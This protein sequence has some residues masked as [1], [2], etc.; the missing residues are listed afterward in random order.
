MA[1]GLYFL[2]PNSNWLKCV[3]KLN[4]TLTVKFLLKFSYLEFGLHSYIHHLHINPSRGFLIDC[5]QLNPISLWNLA[6]LWARS[7]LSYWSPFTFLVRENSCFSL[8]A[9]LHTASHHSDLLL[10]LAVLKSCSSYCII[11]PVL[12]QLHIAS[13]CSSHHWTV[14]GLGSQLGIS[15]HCQFLSWNFDSSDLICFD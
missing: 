11:H 2:E 12:L 1:F 9:N 15:L 3:A 4:Q 7:S 13:C 10:H 14:T 6:N 5:L 8:T